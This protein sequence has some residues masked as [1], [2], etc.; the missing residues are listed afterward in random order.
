[1]VP[2]TLSCSKYVL[3]TF[4][5]I[6]YFLEIIKFVL[7]LSE[8]SAAM[9]SFRVDHFSGLSRTFCSGL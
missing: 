6:M 2:F 9:P 4:V 3:Q 7:F 8:V 1:M 5:E